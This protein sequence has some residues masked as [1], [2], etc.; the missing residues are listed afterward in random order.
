MHCSYIPV[1]S[2]NK[3]IPVANCEGLQGCEMSMIPHFLSWRLGCQPYPL[4][5]L[6]SHKDLLVLISV[7]G[8]V[9]PRE[10]LG[11]FK[12]FN[13]LIGT[14]TGGLPASSIAPQPSQKATIYN[15]DCENFKSYILSEPL[16]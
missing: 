16:G 1:K 5:A 11:K 8:W 10:V 6:Y 12:K 4:A 14:Q 3:A 2:K 7:R 15:H 13:D 9:N